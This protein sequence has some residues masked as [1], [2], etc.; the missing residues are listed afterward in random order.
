MRLNAF[1]MV[2]SNFLPIAVS[3]GDLIDSG[4]LDF[5]MAT[6][7]EAVCMLPVVNSSSAGFLLQIL[8]ACIVILC[9]IVLS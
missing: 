4:L 1:Y 9:G 2:L 6:D 8:A 7:L 3:S 5:M